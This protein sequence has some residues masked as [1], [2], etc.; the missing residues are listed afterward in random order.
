MYGLESG[1]RAFVKVAKDVGEAGPAGDGVEAVANARAVVEGVTE[2][3]R[4][5]VEGTA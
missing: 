2:A 5:W 1:A 4:P 3:L